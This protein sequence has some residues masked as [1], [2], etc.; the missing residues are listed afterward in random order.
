MA[1]TGP[2]SV[3]V[4][5]TTKKCDISV[6]NDSVD[7]GAQVIG[8]TLRQ[9]I[10]IINK[11]AKG[12][13]FDFI[14]LSGMKQPTV[15]SAGTSLGRMTTADESIKPHTAS[16]KSAKAK[17]KGKTDRKAKKRD[18]MA[19]QLE[20]AELE[21]L[22]QEASLETTDPVD[23]KLDLAEP[24]HDKE[25]D[26]DA[27]FSH[28]GDNT[29]DL[30]GMTVGEVSEGEIGPFGSVKLEIIYQPTLPG[31]VDVDFELRFSDG[32]SNSVSKTI[33]DLHVTLKNY[34][35]LAVQKCNQYVMSGA[36]NHVCI[37]H[38]Y[39]FVMCL[40]YFLTV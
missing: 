6:A 8:E 37:L 17:G 21:P 33:H 25:E 14:K 40:L 12:T 30:D 28:Q 22:K 20:E 10:T 11:G 39:R 19:K 23:Q 34:A 36:F 5:C 16:A 18:G 31:R 7:F 13:K 1:Q 4:H 27:E 9:T 24:P 2:F 38:P 26:E 15:L 32:D 29:A 3:P 35:M